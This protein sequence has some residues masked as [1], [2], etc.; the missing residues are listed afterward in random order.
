MDYDSSV[1]GGRADL[2]S[3]DEWL[4]RLRRHLIDDDLSDGGGDARIGGS[5]LSFS[6]AYAESNRRV[7]IA[8]AASSSSSSQPSFSFEPDTATAAVSVAAAPSASFEPDFTNFTE[9]FKGCID[10]LLYSNHPRLTLVDVLPVLKPRDMLA[11]QCVGIP[12]V[13]PAEPSDHLPLA[14]TFNF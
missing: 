3:I 5:S 9:S 2:A 10:Y 12:S 13:N 6:S 1:S 11:A 8:A 14:A 7:L 4:T